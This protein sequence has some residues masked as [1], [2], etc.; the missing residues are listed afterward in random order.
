M[1]DLRRSAG[2]PLALL[3]LLSVGSAGVQAIEGELSEEERVEV[4]RLLRRNEHPSVR[5]LCSEVLAEVP[6]DADA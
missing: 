4:E 3:L 2:L 6:E 5:E 1:N